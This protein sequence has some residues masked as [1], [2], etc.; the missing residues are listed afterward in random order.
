[1][2]GLEASK[3][4]CC[5]N[6]IVSAGLGS[7]LEAIGMNVVP[8]PVQLLEDACIVGLVALF[9]HLQSKHILQP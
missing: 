1:M 4:T 9:L 6:I 5:A 3:W 8:H 2:W 7:F